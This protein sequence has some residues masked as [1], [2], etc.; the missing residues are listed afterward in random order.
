VAIVKDAETEET[1]DSLG[2]KYFQDVDLILT[3]G[4][5]KENKPKI[6]IFRSQVHETPLCRGDEN[7]VA[8][9]SDM[10]L[11]LDVPRFAPDDIKGLADFVERRFLSK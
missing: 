7:L 1:L 2:A 8:L 3:E 11:N 10:T 6:E 5:K 4:Y 9:V